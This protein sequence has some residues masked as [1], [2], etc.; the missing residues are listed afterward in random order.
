MRRLLSAVLASAAFFAVAA[1]SFAASPMPAMSSMSMKKMSC[2]TGTTMVKGYKKADGT[3][4]KAYCRKSSM[5]SSMMMS[6][7]PKATM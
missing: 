7:A 2:P 4:V 6:P 5:K 1:P 3:M